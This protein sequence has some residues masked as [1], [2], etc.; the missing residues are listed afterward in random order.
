MV[1]LA[2]LLTLPEPELFMVE[3]VEAVLEMARHQA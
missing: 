2:L 3:V 1:A